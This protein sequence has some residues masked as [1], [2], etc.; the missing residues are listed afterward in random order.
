[1]RSE[2]VDRFLKTKDC[3]PSEDLLSLTLAAFP[4]ESTSEI[5]S[6]LDVCD[7]CAAEAHFLSRF[8]ATEPLWSITA[9]PPDIRL[10]AESLLR[11][12][13]PEIEL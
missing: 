13:S 7:F 12:R 11:K 10:L 8:Q 1:M 6:H 4:I 9:I 5:I 3:P 2:K